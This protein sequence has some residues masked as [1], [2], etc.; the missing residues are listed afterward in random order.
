MPRSAKLRERILKVA[1][2]KF[3]S[4]GFYKVSVDSL[5]AELRTSKSSIY[6]FFSSK[7]DL[8]ATLVEQLNGIINKQLQQIVD[9]PDLGFEDKL[10]QTTRFTGKLLG[11]VS[12]RFIEDLRIHTPELWESY[13]RERQRRIQIYYRRLFE[14]GI[15][16]GLIR[17]DIDL[18]LIILAYL[19]LTELTVQADKLAELPYSGEEVYE[20]ITTLFL[21]GALSAG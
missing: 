21:E 7:E 19:Q 4:Q 11:L 8:V 2:E 12:E 5:V 6:K 9:H 17:D 15:R 18:Q 10:L 14:Q 16:E 3:L 20:H 1:G 13:Q